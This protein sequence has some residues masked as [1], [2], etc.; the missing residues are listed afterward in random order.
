MKT[1]NVAMF[2]LARNNHTILYWRVYEDSRR[3]KITI[4]TAQ[5]TASR[6]LELDSFKGRRAIGMA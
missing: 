5:S 6:Y 2:S 3:N 4:E 1:S